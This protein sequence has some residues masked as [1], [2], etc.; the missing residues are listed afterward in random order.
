MLERK[1]KLRLK[2]LVSRNFAVQSHKLCLLILCSPCTLPSDPN[3]SRKDATRRI[4]KYASLCLPPLL[5]AE[6]SKAS[7]ITHAT[8]LTLVCQPQVQTL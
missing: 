1:W 5:P 6:E 3:V 8:D 2:Y 7:C 4:R